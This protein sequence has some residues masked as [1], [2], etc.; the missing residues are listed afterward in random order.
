MRIAFSSRLGRRRL[1]RA[2]GRLLVETRRPAVQGKTTAAQVQTQAA[3]RRWR[4]GS[5]SWCT[6]AGRAPAAVTDR[7]ASASAR[8]PR[9]GSRGLHHY[10][11]HPL[12][13][14]GWEPSGST[15]LQ[16]LH[17]SDD[18]VRLAHQLQP[19]VPL[20]ACYV[21]RQTGRLRAWG[22]DGRWAVLCGL[23]H[24]P[25]IKSSTVCQHYR[26]LRPVCSTHTPPR[27]PTGI[28][29]SQQPL[30]LG[31]GIAGRVLCGGQLRASAVHLEHAPVLPCPLPRV[32]HNV[33]ALGRLVEGEGHHGCGCCAP[34]RSMTAEG[35]PAAAS[36]RR[37][38][39][40]CWC[41]G[42]RS[43]ARW[44]PVSCGA[45]GRGCLGLQL[46]H[47]AAHARPPSYGEQGPRHRPPFGLSDAQKSL[48][49]C[50]GWAPQVLGGAPPAASPQ[51][52]RP[53]PSDAGCVGQAAC[54]VRLDKSVKDHRGISLDH[55]PPQRP[56]G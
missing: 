1:P 9:D 53:S 49:S 14:P 24:R 48:V 54:A 3:H 26:A 41:G 6:A 46:S 39:L 22:A 19:A 38:R 43:A 44:P 4:P 15:H 16:E 36:S 32:P 13:C 10:G 45:P 35:G 2:L 40:L 20:V 25:R 51:R 7:R 31:L 52:S 55:T 42:A 11:M 37:A 27:Q 47:I 17:A 18:G 23:E 21:G 12:P 30:Q 8:C 33:K 29:C 28:E 50:A 56:G 34:T 5:A